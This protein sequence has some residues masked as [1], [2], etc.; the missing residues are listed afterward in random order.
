MARPRRRQELDDLFGTG[1]AEAHGHRVHLGGGG[2]Q[3]DGRRLPGDAGGVELQVP[4]AKNSVPVLRNVPTFNPIHL[5]FALDNAQN[6]YFKR[7]ALYDEMR[8]RRSRTWP[9]GRQRVQGAG[10]MSE[11]LSSTRRADR[12]MMRDPEQVIKHAEAVDD[13]L[14]NYV[15]YTAKE[16]GR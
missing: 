8:A 11:M 5:M 2:E 13:V 9:G 10:P 4:G 15:R 16:R 6:R 3:P 1:P 14:G 7:V 12:A